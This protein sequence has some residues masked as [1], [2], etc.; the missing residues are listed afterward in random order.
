MEA[1]L[2]WRRTD[3]VARRG[4]IMTPLRPRGKALPPA[5]V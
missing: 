4:I 5:N 3:A 1:L 2:P